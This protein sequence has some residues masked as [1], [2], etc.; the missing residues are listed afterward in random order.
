MTHPRGLTDAVRRDWDALARPTPD[1]APFDPGAVAE[2]PAPVRRW[3]THAIA[4]GTPLRTAVELELRGEIRLGS[5]R[6]FTATQR[7]TP[8]GLVWAATAR[9]AGLPI[10][11]FDRLT[12][13][14]GEMRWR[15]LGAIPAMSAKGE[16]VTRSAQG[17]LAGELLVA[18]PA[19]A[20]ACAWTSTDDAHAT[21]TVDDHE[22]T[23]T[24]APDGAL[25]ALEMTRWGDPHG[26]GYG[27]HRFWATFAGEVSFDGVTLPR[28]VTAGWGEDAFIRYVVEAARWA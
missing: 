25:A 9:V 19:A 13:G 12:R 5:W 27:P 16:D 2:L 24:I 7:M 11:G 22:V 3:L 23:L 17:R 10:V 26:S 15:L 14:C 28:S 1:P 4:A 18:V 6:S 8:D 21:A 20:P